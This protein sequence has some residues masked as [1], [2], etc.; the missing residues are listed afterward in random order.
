[1]QCNVHKEQVTTSY[2]SGLAFVTSLNLNSFVIIFLT[3]SQE[4]LR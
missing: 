3:P 1:M 2:M 4:I